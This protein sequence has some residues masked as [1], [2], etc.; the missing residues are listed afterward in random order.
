MKVELMMMDKYKF[1]EFIYTQRKKLGFTQEELGRKLKVTNKAVS[2]WETGETL[3][4]IQLLPELAS[5]LNVTIDELLTQ[6]KPEVK[7]VIVDPKK[8]LRKILW[9]ICSVLLILSISLSLVVVK[10]VTF[11]E[12]VEITTENAKDYFEITPCE[13]FVVEGYGIDV[14]GSIKAKENIVDPTLVLN[15]TVQYYYVN[16]EGYLS[17]IVY[18]DRYVSYDSLTDN[19]SIILRPISQIDNFKSFHRVEISYEIIEANGRYVI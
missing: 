18:V 2:K 1:G 3:P 7:E 6:I 12:E 14:F 19:F 8:N 11:K 9:V 13:N 15:F 16:D 10:L 17:E 4:D 5:V